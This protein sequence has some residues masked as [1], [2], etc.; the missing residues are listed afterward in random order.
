MMKNNRNGKIFLVL[1]AAALVVCA[2][3]VFWFF[4]KKGQ[5]TEDNSQRESFGKTEDNSAFGVSDEDVKKQSSRDYV[6]AIIDGSVR[7]VFLLSGAIGDG[8]D[9]EYER[10]SKFSG[11]G[12]SEEDADIVA[13]D[14]LNHSGIISVSG[15]GDKDMEYICDGMKKICEKTDVLNKQYKGVEE[16]KDGKS[17]LWSD[18]DS[19]S[20]TIWGM[21]ND[22]EKGDISPIYA[23][24]TQEAKCDKTSGPESEKANIPPGSISPSRE[25]FVVVKQNDEPN[26]RTGDKWELSLYSKNNFSKPLKTYDIS[27][28]IDHDEVIAYDSVKSIAW[29][30][31][32]R[33]LIFAT[34]RNI[35]SL[36]SSNG[37]VRKIYT[38]ESASE[39]DDVYWDGGLIWVSADGNSV[40]FAGYSVDAVANDEVD[41]ETADT[42]MIVDVNSGEGREFLKAKEVEIL[43]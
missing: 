41:D 9:F 19:E 30:D 39:D 5:K 24:D 4:A 18:W 20:K 42:L 11:F 31:G 12:S 8:D 3:V 15:S 27:S 25:H 29:Y 40:V 14:V 2:A 23:C 43:P 1:A 10:F 16:F 13:Y 17:L 35:F 32:D 37:D 22:P 28:A 7:R 21:V 26:I 36:D 34:A 6:S 33:K 38:M